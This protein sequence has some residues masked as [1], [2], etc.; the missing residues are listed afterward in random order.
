MSHG[1]RR[2]QSPAAPLRRVLCCRRRG[3]DPSTVGR[4]PLGGLED[5]LREFALSTREGLALMVLAEALLRV[6]DA[7]TQDR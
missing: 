2:R 7:A 3:V 6:P 5:F 4:D 1:H